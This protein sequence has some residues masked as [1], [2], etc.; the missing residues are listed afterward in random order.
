[1][2][3]HSRPGRARQQGVVLII[4]LILLVV[5]ATSSA[6]VMR[7]AQ[8]S[9]MI[10]Q[11]V[12][13]Q[14]LAM[15]WA[16]AGLRHCEDL[17]AADPFTTPMLADAGSEPDGLEWR[18]EANWSARAIRLPAG[19]VEGALDEDQ[20]PQCLIRM[21]TV[22]DFRNTVASLPG[23]PSAESRGIDPERF[24]LYRITARGFSPDFHRD[25]EGQATSGAE[26]HLQSMV[27]TI[28]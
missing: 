4:A 19:L 21:L 12:R 16:E 14:A 18:S 6:M 20:R 17:V 2:T 13:A 23:T 11:N 8:F 24:V 27:R 28:E 15:Q 3:C 1:M 5:I 9:G 26:V 7:Q 10:S 22:D 25:S